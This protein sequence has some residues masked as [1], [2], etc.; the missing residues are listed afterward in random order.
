MTMEN[1]TRP[2]TEKDGW[3]YFDDV[4]PPSA[5]SH[6]SDPSGSRLIRVT[7]A[8]GK[9]SDNG[10]FAKEITEELDARFHVWCKVHRC[11]PGDGSMM[12]AVTMALVE[13]G[14]GKMEYVEPTKI[15]FENVKD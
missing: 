3:L 7:V 6:C 5:N 15:Q 10:F 12:Q 13:F 9:Y 1:K 8:T 4:K 2:F 11:P 14:N